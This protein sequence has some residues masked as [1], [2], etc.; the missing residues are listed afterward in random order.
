MLEFSG[1]VPYSSFLAQFTGFD[2]SNQAQQATLADADIVNNALGISDALAEDEFL[3]G[4]LDGNHDMPDGNSASGSLGTFDPGLLETQEEA[5]LSGLGIDP[6]QSKRQQLRCV[7]S[8]AAQ[9]SRKPNLTLLFLHSL[10]IDPAQS[11][12]QQLRC[13]YSNSCSS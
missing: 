12:R 9:V 11:K 4:D 10:G 13:V 6:K 3:V 2:P 8:K 1:S 5:F 7:Y